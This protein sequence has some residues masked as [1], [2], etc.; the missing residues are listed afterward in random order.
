MGRN[1]G[2][3]NLIHSRTPALVD[4]PGPQTEGNLVRATE[5]TRTDLGIPGTLVP[6]LRIGLSP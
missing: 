1:P 6:P 3:P 5:V 2:G 4:Y